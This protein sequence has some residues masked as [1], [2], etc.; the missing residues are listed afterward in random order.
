M[1][2]FFAW[3]LSYY[4]WVGSG[5]FVNHQ[6]KHPNYIF[7]VII[8]VN[9]YAEWRLPASPGKVAEVASVLFESLS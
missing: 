6:D 7:M 1:H 9:V 5:G 8:D 3:F 4:H 2:Q